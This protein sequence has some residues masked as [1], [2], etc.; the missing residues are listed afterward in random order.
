M[1]IPKTCTYCGKA[2]ISL[3]PLNCVA[4][5]AIQEEAKGRKSKLF[6]QTTANN[7]SHNLANC[8]P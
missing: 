5:N 2:Y 8:K 1:A 7:E 3:K 6:N 4:L